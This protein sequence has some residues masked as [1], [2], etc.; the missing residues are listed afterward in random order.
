MSEQREVKLHSP[1]LKGVSEDDVRRFLVARTRSD[2]CFSC[3][4]RSWVIKGDGDFFRGMAVGMEPPDNPQ[5]SLFKSIDLAEPVI[6]MVC[7]KCGFVRMH[8]LF[9]INL[10]LENDGKMDAALEGLGAKGGDQ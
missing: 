4:E 2:E 10:W 6:M 5:V 9:M 1:A 8:D 7:A 3:G